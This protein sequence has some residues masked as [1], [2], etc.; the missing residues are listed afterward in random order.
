MLIS[1][2]AEQGA[3]SF[4]GD[5]LLVGDEEDLRRCLAARLEERARDDEGA[6]D[7]TSGGFFNEPTFA[8]TRTRDAGAAR[9]F[10]SLFGGGARKD[11]SRQEALEKALA[12]HALSVSGTRLT[13]EGFEKKTRSAF[14]QFGEIGAMLAPGNEA[15]AVRK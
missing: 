8:V 12:R 2:D 10:V 4:V 1:S 6:A 13:P 5:Y 7:G 11:A 3:A 9:T 15:D 14:G